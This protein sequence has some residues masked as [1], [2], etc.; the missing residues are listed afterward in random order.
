MTLEIRHEPLEQL[1]GRIIDCACGY[2]QEGV[3][4]ASVGARTA[5]LEH[6]ARAVALEQGWAGFDAVML[7]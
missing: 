2:E 7:A 6:L 5:Y 4:N 3:Y 1:D